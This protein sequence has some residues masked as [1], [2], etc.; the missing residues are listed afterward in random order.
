LT[1][2]IEANE[3]A[4]EAVKAIDSYYLVPCKKPSE[5]KQDD[6]SYILNYIDQLVHDYS[7]CFKR[8]NGLIPQVK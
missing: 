2:E 6:L 3:A 1:S 7:E 8:H 4:I 5:M